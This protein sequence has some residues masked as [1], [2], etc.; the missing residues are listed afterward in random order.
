MAADG[1]TVRTKQDLAATLQ[2]LAVAS[3]GS[4]HAWLHGHPA[5]VEFEFATQAFTPAPAMAPAS[6]GAKPAPAVAECIVELRNHAEHGYGATYS[7][8]CWYLDIAK[9]CGVTGIDVSDSLVVTSVRGPALGVVMSDWTVTAVDETLVDNKKQLAAALHDI[10]VGAF[11]RFVFRKANVPGPE[12]TNSTSSN[13]RLTLRRH[14]K[15]GYG[16]DFDDGLVVTSL[17]ADTDASTKVGLGWRLKA[18]AG[19]SV[20][21]KRQLV[22]VLCSASKL[23]SSSSAHDN[24]STEFLFSHTE[25]LHSTKPS[26]TTISLDRD[27]KHGFGLD[28]D[29]SLSVV[30]VSR[31]PR[32]QATGDFLAAQ[33][34]SINRLVAVNGTEVRTKHE[35]LEA[36]VQPSTVRSAEFRFQQHAPNVQPTYVTSC[37][38]LRSLSDGILKR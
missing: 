6:T 25:P 33:P 1:Q 18:V 36:L 9:T 34:G 15:H 11:A 28:V 30:T 26:T 7:V 14:A 17:R 10:V 22:S 37:H 23:S 2:R 13:S 24:V 4:P 16:L 5:K 27:P 3:A 12:S 21:S 29:D 32:K 31:S 35:L 20:A 8:F 38:A 19:T